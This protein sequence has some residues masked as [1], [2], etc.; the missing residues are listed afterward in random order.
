MTSGSVH[1]PDTSHA[2]EPALGATVA[3]V[4]DERALVK[5]IRT[6][7]ERAFEQLFDAYYDRPH[8]T[9]DLGY[10]YNELPNE[11]IASAGSCRT[12]PPGAA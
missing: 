9:V 6:G 8:G 12:M 2:T 5:R 11:L 4:M 7:D 10:T 3:L 1:C